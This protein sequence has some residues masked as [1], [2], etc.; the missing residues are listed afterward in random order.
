[1]A[2][3]GTLTGPQKGIT[4][5]LQRKA[6]EL[7]AKAL[8]ERI[9]RAKDDALMQAVIPVLEPGLAEVTD[10]LQNLQPVEELILN[11]QKKVNELKKTQK[12]ADR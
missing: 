5:D 1:M 7:T 3:D 12:G 9:S 10:T 11:A 8:K 4:D 6:Y 2:A